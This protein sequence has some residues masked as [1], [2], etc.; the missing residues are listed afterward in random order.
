MLTIAPVIP[1]P[2]V[3]APRRS[4][5]VTR[6]AGS[7]L[8][9]DAVADGGVAGEMGAGAVA[10]RA[11]K[12]KTTPITTPSRRGGT[13]LIMASSKAGPHGAEPEPFE[14]RP[15]L[16]GGGVLLSPVNDDSA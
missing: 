8:A 4:M 10:A 16:F 14:W 1:L 13:A 7:P 9:G 11:V 5:R 2:S 6:S 15:P 3:A 12:A